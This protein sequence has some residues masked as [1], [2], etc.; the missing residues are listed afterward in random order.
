[1]PLRTT[2]AMFQPASGAL[3]VSE[4]SSRAAP[5]LHL[6]SGERRF[7]ERRCAR[8][9][10]TVTGSGGSVE[11]HPSRSSVLLEALRRCEKFRISGTTAVW[12]AASTAMEWKYA[13]AH[14]RGES[15]NPLQSSFRL[16]LGPKFWASIGGPIQAKT[17][18]RRR[19]ARL[20]SLL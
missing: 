14:P 6:R 9:F 4:Q 2:A 20:D 18:V 19:L 11:R 8:G 16:D 12:T 1:M 15:N 17:E 5:F 10:R 3:R 7:C 13:A